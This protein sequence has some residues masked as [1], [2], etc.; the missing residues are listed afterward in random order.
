MPIRKAIVAK[1]IFEILIKLKEYRKKIF[2]NF[3]K[4][5]KMEIQ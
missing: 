2:L 4:L 3:Q 1:R 5:S